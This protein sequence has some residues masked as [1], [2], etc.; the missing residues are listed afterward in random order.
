M[1]GAIQALPADYE[2]DE[3]PVKDYLPPSPLRH[4]PHGELADMI[5]VDA[6]HT[7][8]IAGI[9]KNLYASSLVL[10]SRLGIFGGGSI[11]RRLQ[12]AYELF[13]DFV[14]RAGKYTSIA[15]FNYMTLKCSKSHLV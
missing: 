10:A 7:W 11:E 14:K 1:K 9:G 8:A 15:T 12:K 5:R 6:A 2:S 4:L 3:S 13:E